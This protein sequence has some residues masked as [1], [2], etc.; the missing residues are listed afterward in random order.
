MRD[1]LFFDKKAD[2]DDFMINNV[3]AEVKTW[4]SPFYDN[5]IQFT[6]DSKS[7]I[8]YT[9]SDPS[10]HFAFSGAYHF[11][12]RRERY[13]N[14]TREALFWLHD[15][16]HM[17]FEYPHDLFNVSEREFIDLFWYQER[18][19]SNETEILSYYRVPGLRE[20]VFPDELLWY[21]VKAAHGDPK[22][23][24]RQMLD[25]R[26]AIQEGNDFVAE[27]EIGDH[28]DILKWVR[29]WVRLTPA[30]CSKRFRSMAGI[31][32]P[33]RNIPRRTVDDYEHLL[34]H[35]RSVATQDDYERNVMHNIH[36]A[37]AI[38]GWDDPPQRWRH[39]PEAFDQ[40][41]GAVFFQR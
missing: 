18:I 38:L 2:Y 22:P 11:E 24:P 8:F 32:V 9:I 17:L 28:P 13:P 39:V 26:R 33:T 15:F 36:M 12:T 10:E 25:T 27:V 7:P 21:D 14:K 1:L 30:W 6:L 20:K 23:T 16:T 35:Y 19:A 37:F 40:L 5:L 31:R 3:L 34:N 4:E 29:S 41:E